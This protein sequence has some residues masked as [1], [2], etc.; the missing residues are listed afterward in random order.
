MATTIKISDESKEK[1]DR[2]RAKLLLQG[3]KYK[4]E[5]LIDLV[6]SMA[7]ANP[8]LVGDYKGLSELEK[9]EFM[10]FTFK[11]SSEKSIDEELYS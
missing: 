6:I 5:E 4:Q 10:S 2:I 7:D 8:V 9:E 3:K 1:L 11:G